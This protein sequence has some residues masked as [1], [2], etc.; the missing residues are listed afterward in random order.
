MKVLFLHGWQSVPGGVKPTF[1]VRHG[2]EVVNPKLPDDDFAEAVR[3]AQAEF[4]R[5]QPQV[6]VGSSRGGA[7]AMNINSGEAKLVLLCPAWKKWGT[8]RTV[9]PGSVILHSRADDVVPFAHSEEL[10]RISGVTLIE[11]GTDHRLA[12]PEPLV[13]ML[14]ACEKRNNPS[15]FKKDKHHERVEYGVV[16]VARLLR[17]DRPFQGTP[18]VCR[19][20]QVGDAGTLVHAY[21]VT[22][23]AVECVNTDGLTVWLADFFAEE[24]E[25]LGE[26]NVEAGSA[27]RD[28]AN[29]P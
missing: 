25:F 7:V 2:H 28:R 21:D 10:A 20:P 17:P 23:F 5:H 9:K 6:V 26:H 29:R 27:E 24:L 11:V 14:K 3:I 13:A 16:R 18:G 4:D 12:D 8:A 19:A 22:S 15:Q 1:L